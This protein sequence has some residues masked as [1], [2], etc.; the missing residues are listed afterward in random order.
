MPL[1]GTG[2]YL[3]PLVKSCRAIGENKGS[4]RPS[5]T[6][7]ESWACYDQDVPEFSFTV[8]VERDEDG[9]FLA[10]CPSLP[11]CY[12]EGDSEAEAHILIEDAIRLHVSDRLEH[13]EPIYEE[14]GVSQVKVAV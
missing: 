11:G 1:A 13:G 2:E 12:T 5:F 14:V 4:R 6:M 7:P 3:K 8:V 9:R 10:I